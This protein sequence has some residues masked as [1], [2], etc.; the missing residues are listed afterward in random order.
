MTRRRSKP[1]AA[2]RIV[3]WA[4]CALI[5]CAAHGCRGQVQLPTSCEPGDR[6]VCYSGPA[7]S[8]GG[9]PCRPGLRACAE[10]GSGFGPCEGE[11][12]PGVEDCA[13]AGDEDCDGKAAVC[14]GDTLWARR[15][16]G[17]EYQ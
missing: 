5:A 6:E 14:A 8:E 10:D 13:L 17:A 4:A 3:T 11:V 7:G 15:F 2:R 1:S 16:V 9:G 12:L